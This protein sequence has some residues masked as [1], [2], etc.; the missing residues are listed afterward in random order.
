[1]PALDNDDREDLPDCI[2]EK[3]VI[4]IVSELLRLENDANSPSYEKRR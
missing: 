2:E 4:P 1:L 3:R